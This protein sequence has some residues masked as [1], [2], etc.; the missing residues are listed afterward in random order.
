MD[1]QFDLFENLIKAI[2]LLKKNFP[3]VISLNFKVL[4]FFVELKA[5]SKD[6][7]GQVFVDAFN[8]RENPALPQDLLKHVS[9][10]LEIEQ[11][12]SDQVNMND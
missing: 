8:H 6:F 10:S 3:F 5:P 4:F 11:A 7:L 2:K 9:E 1:V 12:T